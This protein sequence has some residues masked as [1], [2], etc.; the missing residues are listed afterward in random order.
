MIPN[1]SFV[2]IIR[3]AAS[4]SSQLD[5]N[6]FNPKKFF[7]YFSYNDNNSVYSNDSF[8]NNLDNY[9]EDHHFSNK[10]NNN[11][12]FSLD[13]NKNK[14]TVIYKIKCNFCGK[15]FKR[16]DYLKKHFFYLH[17]SYKGTNCLYFG[18]NIIRI[19]DI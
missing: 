14:V 7:N 6:S 16:K 2:N 3:N 19:K 10:L 17:S 18:K 11:N 4:G 15:I 5:D 9:N 8:N 13:N 12:E 1:K